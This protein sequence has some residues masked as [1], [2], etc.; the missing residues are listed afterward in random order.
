MVFEPLVLQRVQGGGH[1]AAAVGEDG[2]GVGVHGHDRGVAEQP[3]EVQLVA[4]LATDGGNEAHGGGLVVDHA[5]GALG[6]R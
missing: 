5:D 4:H 3:P 1:A 6:R 2:A